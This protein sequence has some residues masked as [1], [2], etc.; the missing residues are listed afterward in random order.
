MLI[1]CLHVRYEIEI[2]LK[3]VI[4]IDWHLCSNVLFVFVVLCCSRVTRSVT[5][6]MTAKRERAVTTSSRS[7]RSP[8]WMRHPRTPSADTNSN[9]DVAA[10]TGVVDGTDRMTV[11]GSA[12][13]RPSACTSHS[14]VFSAEQEAVSSCTHKI[15]APSCHCGRSSRLSS[16][17][18][19]SAKS[20]D[21]RK[22]IG[23]ES[24]V[25]LLES[26]SND[27]HSS[28]SSEHVHHRLRCCDGGECCP[29]TTDCGTSVGTLSGPG[30]CNHSPRLRTSSAST[31]ID[32]PWVSMTERIIIII[33]TF[34]ERRTQSYRGAEGGVN[35]EA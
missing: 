8:Y 30:N 17:I 6:A 35:Q 25:R 27:W 26:N 31:H 20:S 3:L 7:R 28:T 18:P 5:A 10:S 15:H 29:S 12:A 2:Y 34:V 1:V 9:D 14:D 33:I 11:A 24:S 23:S 19:S 16:S 21:G 4:V 13:L 32:R 22:P